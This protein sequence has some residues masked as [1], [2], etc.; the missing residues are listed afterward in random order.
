MDDIARFVQPVPFGDVHSRPQHVN[1]KLHL[2]AAGGSVFIP[3]VT[4]PYYCLSVGGTPIHHVHPVSG[5]IP[6]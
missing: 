4:W 5:F 6:P 3:P 2:L 1:L